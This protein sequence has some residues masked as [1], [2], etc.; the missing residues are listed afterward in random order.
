MAQQQSASAS[1]QE[2]LRRIPKQPECNIGTS[3]HVDHGKCLT[4][5][6]YVILGGRLVTGK[7]ILETLESRGKLVAKL[8]GGQLYELSE[9]EVVSIS[10]DL[11]PTKAK[12]M[13]YT[14]H[15]QG[16]VFKITT[17]SGRSLKVTPEHPLLANRAGALRWIKARDLTE[18][19]HVAFLS[20][21][22]DFAEPRFADPLPALSQ[23]YRVVTYSEYDHLRRVTNGFTSYIALSARELG[24][25]RVL[26]K[27]SMRRLSLLARMDQSDLRRALDGEARSS[28]RTT[29]K[30]MDAMSRLGVETLRPGEFVVETRRRGK[31]SCSVVRDVALTD[32]LMKWFAFVWAEG[33]SVPSRIA[34]SQTV[35]VG[36]LAEFLDITRREF[37]MEFKKVSDVDYHLSS[38]AIVDLL[39][40]KYDFKAGN[41]SVSSIA[42]WVLGAPHALRATFLRWFFTL[43][44]EFNANSG[45]VMISQ[46]NEK[47]IAVLA[48]LLQSFGIVPRFSETKRSTQKGLKLYSR[49]M[50]SGRQNLERFAEIV[51]FED[52]KIQRKLDEYLSKI[53]N[54]SKETDFSLPVD[55]S[56]LERLLITS[57][58]LRKGFSLPD[59]R[60]AKESD[61]YHAYS[62]SRTTKRLSRTK[63][64]AILE[65]SRASLQQ[66]EASL[67]K[68]DSPPAELRK[69]M[70]LIGFSLE[71]AASEL[72][73]TRKVLTESLRRNDP[74]HV[75]RLAKLIGNF[76]KAGISEAESLHEQFKLVASSPLVFDRIRSVGIDQYEG[77]IFDLTVPGYA[78]FIAGLGAMVAHNTSLVQAITGVWASAHS[79]ELK[80]GITIKV[81]YADAAFYRCPNHE[82]LSEAYSTSPVCPV[83]GKETNLLRAVSFV[84]CPG[85]ESLMTNML[86]GA[87][88]M[89]GVILVIA[90]NEPVPMPQTREHLLALQML[91][92]KK[93][94]VVQNKIDRVDLDGAKKN[95]EA[96]KQFLANTVGADAPVIPV[97]AQNRINID[98]L[99]ESIEETIPTPKHDLSAAPQMYILRSFDV[100]RPGADVKSLGGGGLGG[101]LVNGEIRVGDEVEISPGLAE[102]KTGKYTPILTK[103][104]SLG[105]GA[106]MTERVG[107]GGLI[108]LGTSLDPRLTKGDVLVGNLVGRP[109]SLPPIRS[110]ITVDLQL[111]DQAV[112]SSTLIKVDKVK[113]TETLR[114][115]IGTASTLGTVTS[116]RDT[117]A[118]LDLKKPVVAEEKG[119]VAISRRIAERWRLIGSGLIR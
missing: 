29:S 93:M 84:D 118:E 55:P 28:A 119:R 6:Q 49:M 91:G 44:G 11:Q 99:I 25:I 59:V 95:Y 58:L 26:T 53:S 46:A 110:H 81:G 38:K 78:N 7:T 112:G 2:V 70:L 48:Y 35:Q 97:S 107:P 33:T 17:D 10:N 79:E 32:D 54:V 20:T 67:S 62:T 47:N 92:M 104:S 66:I 100:N 14:E 113:P 13:L 82:G 23:L 4:P 16:A 108:A 90:A 56:Q 102:E 3:G 105:T 85:H 65:A 60:T 50:I 36:M 73:T 1:P 51:G 24:Q 96:I 9:S 86:A 115:N 72:G 12:A 45:Q 87:A 37:G 31:W 43:D 80:R 68:F 52:S 98:A 22:P 106:G 76:A 39:T 117:V 34:V 18:G 111:F 42:E 21:V 8:D 109:G 94:V 114:L 15:Y 41:E 30:I 83:C 40:A 27:T 101:S 103:V 64:L 63:L 5:D 88:L 57:G 74:Q 77:P 69:K 75:E 61:W 19:D 116:A 71:Q 89:D